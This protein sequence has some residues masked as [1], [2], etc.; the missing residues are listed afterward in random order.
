MDQITIAGRK[1]GV[2][3]PPFIIAEMSA[4]H[5]GDLG[6]ALRII[7]LAARAGA[8]AIKFQAYRPETMTLDL[9]APG[10]VIGEGTLWTGE[11]LY[12]LYERAATPY[13]WFPKLFDAARK[14]NII[15]FCSP[16]DVDAIELLEQLDAPAFKIASFE[17]V[18]HELIGRAARSGRPL[19]ISTGMATEIEISEALDAARRGGTKEVALL[20]CTSSYPSDASEANLSTIADMARRFDVPVGLSDHTLGVHVPAAACAMDACI[21]EKHF[22]DA[23]M[24]E[25]A[26]SEFSALPDELTQMVVACRAAWAARGT[27]FY[28]PMPRESHSKMFRRSLYIVKDLAAGE[29]LTRDNVKSIRPGFGIAPKHLPEVLGRRAARALP[30]GTPVSWDVLA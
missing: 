26:D 22:I 12:T 25:T 14:N 8:D 21:I 29:I 16:F 27:V 7:E 6:R 20:K 4:N 30:R 19:I 11:L 15:P 3:N 13:E 28:G 1:I 10:F 18:D 24:P 23:R 9:D 17:I 5:G 2:D